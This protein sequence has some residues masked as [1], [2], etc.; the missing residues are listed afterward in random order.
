MN[1]KKLNRELNFLL[2][3]SVLPITIHYFGKGFDEFKKE[4]IDNSKDVFEGK[5]YPKRHKK[6]YENFIRIFELSN[7]LGLTDNQLLQKWRQSMTERKQQIGNYKK[8]PIQEGRDNKGIYVGSGGSYKGNTVRYP[9]K[10]RSKRVWKIFY[11]M[12][13]HYAKIDGWNGETS[14][15]MI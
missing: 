8:K 6:M 3:T 7:I 1:T 9:S 12:F 5:H 2:S 10:K 15:K 13:P 11:E 14:N 4:K